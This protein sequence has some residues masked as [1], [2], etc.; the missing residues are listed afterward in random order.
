MC[1][2]LSQFF[3]GHSLAVFVIGKGWPYEILYFLRVLRLTGVL[4]REKGSNGLTP[5]GDLAV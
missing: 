1:M 3:Q 5:K 2:C 4:H